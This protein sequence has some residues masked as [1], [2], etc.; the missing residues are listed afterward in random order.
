M[1][2]SDSGCLRVR[3]ATLL[4]VAFAACVAVPSVMAQ[5]DEDY[6]DMMEAE[7][8]EAY[9]SDEYQ[10]YTS[11]AASQYGSRGRSASAG[12][13]FSD[14]MSN[15]M[16]TL[17]ASPDFAT[18]TAGSSVPP[19]AKGPVLEAEARAAYAKGDVKLA[20]NL[21]YG[22]IAAEYQNAQA[23]V[24]A[25]KFSRLMR[26]PDWHLR[27]GVSFMVRGDDVDPQPIKAGRTRGGGGFG[28]PGGFGGEFED[29]GG[30]FEMEEEMEAMNEEY[31]MEMA[32]E[33]EEMMGVGRRPAGRREEAPAPKTAFERLEGIERS[34]ISAEAGTELE[35]VLGLV[36]A[37]L[38][39]QFDSRFTQGDYGSAMSGVTPD[40]VD[41]SIS[42]EFV[43]ALETS[44]EP[45]PM[46]RSGIEFLGKGDLKDNLVVAREHELDLV[47]HIDVLLKETRT[48][49]V[50][51]V[52]RC[53]LV[54]VA[55][56]KSLGVSR[57]VDSM[58][59]AKQSQRREIDPK[60]YVTEQLS[61]LFGI[62]DRDA[63]MLEMPQLTAEIAKRRV[64]MLMSSGGGKNLATLAEIRLYQAQRLLTEDEV[65]QAFDIVGGQQAIRLLHGSEEERLEI[66]RKWAV[67][68]TD[69]EDT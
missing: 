3:V 7:Y 17:F 36:A 55:T 29:M 28:G 54:N 33:M 35:E 64:G 67:G 66:V 45:L 46:W 43:D 56:G 10:N 47:F 59:L 53:R 31:E 51:N 9:G 4:T 68:N 32:S 52:S 18:L 58:E 25:A 39:E 48:D 20:L 65:L 38:G 41:N 19:V 34:M 27:W 2:R 12:D 15:V 6:G 60:D 24:H 50:Q 40:A 8:E 1:K 22:H 63:K 62:V 14:N 57:T 26:R 11:G 44:A 13:L 30:G 69:D 42:S 21:F 5:T 61:N 37:V 16:T 49:F 23:A